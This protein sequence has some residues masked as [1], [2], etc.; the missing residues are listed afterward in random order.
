MIDE[1]YLLQL[2][3]ELGD[4]LTATESLNRSF[5]KCQSISIKEVFSF[6]EQ[7]SFDS[8]SSKFARTS[9]IYTQKI[10]KTIFLLLHE[11]PRSFIDKANLAEKLEII[12]SADDIILI[13]DLRNEIVHEYILLELSRIYNEIFLHYSKLISA[14]E[15][16]KIFINNRNW[17]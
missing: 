11:N 8:L 3:K 9:D 1:K 7:E 14:V 6:E 13:R 5:L 4:L 17:G 2:K 10:L 15:M 12:P 16:T